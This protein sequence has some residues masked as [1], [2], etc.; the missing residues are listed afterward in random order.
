MP[1]E[2]LVQDVG[3]AWRRWRRA[4]RLL[5]Y[6]AQRLIDWVICLSSSGSACFG[7]TFFSAI[8]LLKSI[9]SWRKSVQAQEGVNAR[10][11]RSA[12]SEKRRKTALSLTAGLA[13]SDLRG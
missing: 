11:K 13:C 3:I 7:T 8:S 5:G 2:L 6:L 4:P 12:I 10:P 9:S 1:A